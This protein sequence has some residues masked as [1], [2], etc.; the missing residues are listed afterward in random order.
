[1]IKEFGMIFLIVIIHEFGHLFI[2]YCFK[3]NL[4]KIVIY[5]FGGCVKF[6]EKINRSIREEL[7][8]L[9]GGP[10]SQ[11][12]LFVIIYFLS[13]NGFMTFRN[14]MLFKSYHY[15][16]LI[17][18][19]L[20]IFPLD[21]GRIVNLFINRIF[22]YK[23]GNRIVIV[24][25]MLFITIFLF[26]YKSL[27]F[28]LMSILLMIE[29]V[30]YF[31]NQDYLYNRMLLERYMYDLNYKKIKVIKDKDLMFRDKRHVIFYD[32]KYVTEKDYL[33]ERFR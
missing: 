4:D 30:I 22:P 12:L 33:K 29:L 24:F 5:P 9:L 11:I 26:C 7:L 14:F 21:G 3:W 15:T 32:N 31:K 13:L 25:S 16:L 8:I 6:E 2:S 28:I 18:N 19:L 23:T 1:M 20:P 10:C 27:N 17:F